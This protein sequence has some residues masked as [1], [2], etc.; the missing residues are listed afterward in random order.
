MKSFEIVLLG[1]GKRQK[2]VTEESPKK[3]CR[4]NRS[5]SKLLSFWQ[6]DVVALEVSAH[7]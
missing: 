2:D 5:F 1:G 7:R 4:R 6:S 3:V